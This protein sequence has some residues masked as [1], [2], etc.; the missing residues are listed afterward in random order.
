MN[1]AVDPCGAQVV[2]VVVAVV[3][4][5]RNGD[6]TKDSVELLHPKVSP[7][8]SQL[9]LPDPGDTA[10]LRPESHQRPLRQLL[11]SCRGS[12]V[13][14]LWPQTATRKRNP[15]DGESPRIQHPPT[16]T[17]GCSRGRTLQAISCPLIWPHLEMQSAARP[18]NGQ[19]AAVFNTP[20]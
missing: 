15:S 9:H 4:S 17:R 3:V 6:Q 8:S 14:L 20:G 1:R 18:T 10:R 11:I 2:V 19:Q 13:F 16:R 12:F 5:G 7:P